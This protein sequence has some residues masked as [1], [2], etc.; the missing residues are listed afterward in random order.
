M[1][2]VPGSKKFS[3]NSPWFGNPLP[4]LNNQEQEQ[5]RQLC[6]HSLAQKT[7]SSYSTAE[8]LLKLC[9]RE[10]NIALVLPLSENDLV[11]F[12]LWLA[13]ERK[14]CHS[15][16]SCYLAGVRQLHIQHG[17]QCPNTRSI[18]IK[19]LL[20]GKGN[21]EAMS[22]TGGQA[23]KRRPITPETLLQL[24]TAITEWQDSICNKRRLWCVCTMMFFGAFRASELLCETENTFDLRFTLCQQDIVLLEN[25]E[26]NEKRLLVTV[27]TPK[28]EKKAATLK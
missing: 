8:K 14:V 27:K 2:P 22:A 26:K 15:T 20:K 25:S 24:K 5:V 1:T 21:M 6:G 7:W 10:K 23:D 19:M 18:T 4:H 9:G 28:E 3:G 13:F 16:I 11:R 12:V 17:A